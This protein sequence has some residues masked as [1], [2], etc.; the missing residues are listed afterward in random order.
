MIPG[1][2]VSGAV[3][4]AAAL[5]A[6]PV[7]SWPL[8]VVADDGRRVDVAAA[9]GTGGRR[10]AVLLDRMATGTRPPPGSD[11]AALAAATPAGPVDRPLAVVGFAEAVEA[12]AAVDRAWLAAVDTCRSTARDLLTAAGRGVE[13]E[14]ALHLAM[15]LATTP[16]DGVA[17]ASSG[18]PG[19]SG[20]AGPDTTVA[21]G[22]SGARL[23]LLGGAVAWALLGDEA[24]PFSGWA[25]LVTFGLW[26]VGPVGD[27][28]VVGMPA[29]GA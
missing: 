26:P 28:L 11:I 2:T 14:A 16:V 18:G 12:T 4:P 22:A 19:T 29:G 6:A 5:A 8:E 24:D 7:V 17:G 15:L 23:W 9:L 25:E 10:V 1:A 20:G 13:L 3:S 21:R 27:R